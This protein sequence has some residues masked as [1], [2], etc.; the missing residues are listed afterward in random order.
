MHAKLNIY[1]FITTTTAGA[2]FV[3]DGIIRPIKK[4]N[5]VISVSLNSLFSF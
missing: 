2:L 4:N 5:S 1:S 3:P